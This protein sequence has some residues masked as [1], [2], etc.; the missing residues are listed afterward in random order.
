MTAS[1]RNPK[2]QKWPDEISAR[3]LTF[4][5]VGKDFHPLTFEG[6][7][8]AIPSHL[9]GVTLTSEGTRREGA[10]PTQEIPSTYDGEK[11]SLKIRIR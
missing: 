3:P 10:V 8:R 9:R 5:G 6:A 4:E 11:N 1:A 7:E 2:C